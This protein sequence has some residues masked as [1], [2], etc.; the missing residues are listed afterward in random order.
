[1]RSLVC[2]CVCVLFP[3]RLYIPTYAPEALTFRFS[4][5]QVALKSVTVE[6][7]ELQ[8][9]AHRKQKTRLVQVIE[10]FWADDPSKIREVLKSQRRKLNR[11]IL[12]TGNRHPRDLVRFG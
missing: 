11:S 7:C 6:Q 5:T 10:K 3:N 9:L 8:L 4:G 12:G 1:M 2:V